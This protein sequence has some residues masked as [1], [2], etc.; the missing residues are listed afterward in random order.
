MNIVVDNTARTSWFAVLVRCFPLFFAIIARCF[1]LLFGSSDA[2]S[3]GIRRLSPV[4]AAVLPWKKSEKQRLL[5]GAPV[6]S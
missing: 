6:L 2:K 1:L 4:G 5:A 3:R